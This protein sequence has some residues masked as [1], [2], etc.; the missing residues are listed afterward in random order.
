[1]F[2]SSRSGRVEIWVANADGTQ[3]VPLTSLGGI[4]NDF[5]RWSA[6]GHWI[7]FHHA[8]ADTRNDIWV[9]DA[10]GGTPH[11]LTNGPGADNQPSFSH[12]GK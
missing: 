2:D 5:P 6:D 8:A 11:R 4:N 12:D 9:I 1:V 3:P 10:E 7:A